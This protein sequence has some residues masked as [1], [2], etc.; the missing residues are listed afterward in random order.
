MPKQIPKKFHLHK[1]AAH[2]SGLFLIALLVLLVGGVASFGAWYAHTHTGRMFPGVHIGTLDLG[3]KTQAQASIALNERIDALLAQ[4]LTF[5]LK[6]ERVTFSS[7]D[8]APDDPDLS[9]ELITFEREGALANAHAFG[10]GPNPVYNFVDQLRARFSGA[11]IQIPA[12]LAFTDVQLR[13]EE[14][15]N[16]LLIPATNAALSVV[17]EEDIPTIIIQKEKQGITFNRAATERTL[18]D[19]LSHLTNTPVALTALPDPPTI[20]TTDVTLVLEHA[21]DLLSRGP[22][23]LTFEHRQW[24]IT[25]QALSTMLLVK[26]DEQGEAHLIAGGTELET[27]FDEIGTS[28]NR[29]P[30]DAK[31]ALQ[32]ARVVEFQSS[33]TGEAL[34]EERTALLMTEQ[35]IAQGATGI[36][37]ATTTTEPTITTAQVNDLGIEE[38]LGVGTSNFAGSPRNRVKNIQNGARLVNGTL[39]PPGETFSLI[40]SLGPFT[41]NNGY[42]PE[43]VIKGDKIIPEIGGGLC[44]LGT[45][46]FRATMNSGLPVTM[47]RNHS[48]VVSYYSDPSN[49]NPGTDATIYDPAPDFRFTNDTGKHML[50]TTEVD[51]SKTELR[52]LFWG[53]SDGRK[54][55]YSPPVVDRWIPAGATK[56]IETIDLAPGK[57]QCQ[58][59]HVGADTHFTYT[60]ERPNG[61]PEETL[62]ESHY[63]ALPRVCLIGVAEPAEDSGEDML[64]G[65]TPAETA[66]L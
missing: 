13:I 11:V 29:S 58:S 49:G 33:Q 31:F 21:E 10:R 60:I 39:I 32:G 61:E 26:K 41:L 45:T 20:T 43:L 24:L 66:D 1:I 3:G 46:T 4:G 34:D 37:V 6:G 40:R 17:W 65:L 44:Q 19:L 35:F 59:K 36:E 16:T 2:H 57:E 48:L 47:R 23:T 15:F 54:G 55:Y 53:A 62:F 18:S 25:P 22:W 38:L 14:Q 5:E 64:E 51:I 56:Y 30:R 9:R 8:I 27:L 12:T 50:V 63:R 28:I 7:I 52:F 42:L